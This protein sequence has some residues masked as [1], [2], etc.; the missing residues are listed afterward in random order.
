M[1][2]AKGFL[3]HLICRVQWPLQQSGWRAHPPGRGDGQA[4]TSP[5]RAPGTLA[6]TDRRAAHHP[7]GRKVRGALSAVKGSSPQ[8]VVDSLP[9]QLSDVPIGGACDP[10]VS[11]PHPFADS[12]DIHAAT[13]QQVG[14]EAVP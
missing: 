11:V 7:I 3:G 1:V 2:Q 8:N 13:G 10:R 5:G 12:D 14:T 4:D 6:S 9:G